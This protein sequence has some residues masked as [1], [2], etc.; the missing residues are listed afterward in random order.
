M[1]YHIKFLI[2]IGIIIAQLI[3]ITSQITPVESAA[4]DETRAAETRIANSEARIQ[5]VADKIAA[6]KKAIED[7]IVAE[8]KAEE[9]RIA[10]MKKAEDDKLA[11][12]QKAV[13]DKIAAE[14]K[15]TEDKIADSKRP[16]TASRIYGLEGEEAIALA[17]KYMVGIW[18]GSYRMGSDTW[19]MRWDVMADGTM[20]IRT[21]SQDLTR[22]VRE[23]LRNF[24]A[25]KDE[26]G[27]PEKYQ[28]KI[29][30]GKYYNTGAQY[31]AIQTTR[32]A[33]DP[34]WYN[35]CKGAITLGGWLAS[36]TV[37]FNDN[38]AKG[39]QIS[40]TRGDHSPFAQAGH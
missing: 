2:A 37:E 15:A 32:D 18:T 17:Q 3:I 28:W 31:Y 25:A 12:E 30:V 40:M 26:W 36:D 9:D 33:A 1:K 34:G 27:D 16:I 10:A 14:K 38:S 7:K 23:A 20:T 13:A 4:M 21:A 8:K 19:W 35:G 39:D 29:V 22:A 24:D 6:E 11:A 5:N